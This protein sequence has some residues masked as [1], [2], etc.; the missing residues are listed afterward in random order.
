M[1]D[2]LLGRRRFLKDVPAGLSG[3]LGASQW[4]TLLHANPLDLPIG[5]QLGW[6]K[7]ECERDLDGTLAQLSE[8][9]Y[10]EVEAFQPFFNRPPGEFRRTLDRHGLKCP[11]AHWF[12]HP[13]D[14]DWQ[15]PVEDAKKIGLRYIVMLNSVEARAMKSLDD[16]RQTAKALNKIGEQCRSMGV[17]LAVHNHF[18]EFR[19]LEGTVIY[20]LLIMQS[21]PQLVSFELDCM[22]CKF[23][24][25]DPAEYLQRYPGRFSLLHIKDMKP[26]YGP[27]TEKVVGQPFTEVGQ[28]VLDWKAVFAA[29]SRAGIKHYFVEQD[30]CDRPAL[31]SAK[32]SCDFLKGLRV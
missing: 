23:A 4:P 7:E 30:R 29:A 15:K 24:G 26:G 21:D 8:F 16:C 5:T 6:L 27:S 3:L 22:W 32:M 14:R 12:Y 19:K 18:S 10:R 25:Q 20:D 1:L 31:E 9:G 11:S 2:E 28:G 17:Q 13:T